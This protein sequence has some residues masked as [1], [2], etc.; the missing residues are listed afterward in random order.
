MQP[1]SLNPLADAPCDFV[2]DFLRKI[3]S[4]TEDDRP[5]QA[6]IED[7][8][9]ALAPALVELRDAG[10]VNLNMAVAMSY[11]TLD[12]FIRLAADERLSSLSR[13]RCA[14]I[15]DRLIVFGIK[16]RFVRS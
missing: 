6:E 8:I 12:G 1:T 5:T 15:R 16:A 3:C 2:E 7:Q 11:G 14:A 9:E 13:A 10:H 4:L